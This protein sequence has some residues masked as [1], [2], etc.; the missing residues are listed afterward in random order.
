MRNGER[1]AVAI[2]LATGLFVLVSFSALVVDQGMLLAARLDAQNAADAAAL[3][4]AAAVASVNETPAVAAAQ[5]VSIAQANTVWGEP[6]NIT[7]DDVVFDTCD[8]GS[9]DQ[10][11]R[12]TVFRTAA[13]ENPLPS[14]FANL[15]DIA[16]LDVA[17]TATA[18]VASGNVTDC[19]RPW[20]IPDK[21]IENSDCR[22]NATG[23]WDADSTFDT[24]YCSGPNKGELL[25][26]PDVYIPPTSQSPGTGFTVADYGS[27]LV[28]KQGDLVSGGWF[29]A[30]AV[31]R[32]DNGGQAS[33]GSP[34]YKA[35]IEGCNGVF[36]SFGTEI[37]MLPGNRVGP[38]QQGVDT[39]VSADPDA[40]WDAGTKRIRG[41]CA[42]AG[43]CA[44]SPRLVAV[45]TFDM[46][47]FANGEGGTVTIRNLMGFFIE[48]FDG[49]DLVGYLTYYPGVVQKGAPSVN[50]AASFLK[51][52]VLAK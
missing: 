13:R 27:R 34:A 44:K 37:D 19:L 32:A 7:I 22:G 15:F 5:A 1:G 6:P 45:G 42:A 10:C 50:G 18:R 30:L 48:G 46:N 38:T 40:F 41:G 9:G 33:N 47:D 25:P 11:I 8:D 29:G 39:L 3:A 26:N 24:Q 2:Q 51:K 12:T 35:N 20:A 14:M 4:A 36:M 16:S 28:L 49:N 31:P 23:T 17:A 52:P 43:T 21:W